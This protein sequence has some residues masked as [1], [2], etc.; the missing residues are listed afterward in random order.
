MNPVLIFS[1]LEYYLLTPIVR[2]HS[3]FLFYF[4]EIKNNILSITDTN[5]FLSFRKIPELFFGLFFLY[6]SLFSLL[7]LQYILLESLRKKELQ[8]RSLNLD[9][10]PNWYLIASKAAPGFL[11]CLFVIL[12]R[13]SDSVF[14]FGLSIALFVCVVS[15]VL[16]E[17]GFLYG[18]LGFTIAQ[19]LFVV[20]YALGVLFFYPTPLAIFLTCITAFAIINYLVFFLRYLQSSEKG[21]GSYK[22]PVLIYCVLLGS[23]LVC[24]VL[25]WASSGILS[26]I[27]LVIGGLFF[28]VSDSI[29]AIR[30]FH[31]RPSVP[32]I[33]VMT[34]YYGALF[35]ISF[36]VLAVLIP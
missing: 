27:F 20:T 16:I 30:E 23:M 13:P 2:F 3:D 21:L 1:P 31:H 18:M 35:L 26:P 14:Y 24:A 5:P 28:I 8:V 19:T 34:T 25:L 6:V 32:T 29:I 15:D 11:A 10:I 7:A 4:N 33:K 12:M 22:I 17:K 9:W 36:G